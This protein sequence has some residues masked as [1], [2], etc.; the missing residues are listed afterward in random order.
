MLHTGYHK[1]SG[2]G[3]EE[4]G[5]RRGRQTDRQT[6]EQGFFFSSLTSGGKTKWNCCNVTHMYAQWCAF[7][8]GREGWS[9]REDVSDVCTV[10]YVDT[11]TLGTTLFCVVLYPYCP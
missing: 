4:V 11:C 1:A 2:G 8:D 10:P 5:C 9:D 7:W 6:N 3:G